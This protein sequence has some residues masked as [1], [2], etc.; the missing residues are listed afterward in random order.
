MSG[1]MHSIANTSAHVVASGVDPAQT[2]AKH[3]YPLIKIYSACQCCA[4]GL[5]KAVHL[6]LAKLCIAA[7]QGCASRQ[8]RLVRAAHAK[9]KK[10]A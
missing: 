7:C 8:Y 1:D 6:G 10:V 9:G 2:I 4:S 3:R 5:G